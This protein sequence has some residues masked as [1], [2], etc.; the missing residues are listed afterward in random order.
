MTASMFLAG[1]IL[2]GLLAAQ[3]Y[4]VYEADREYKEALDE[5]LRNKKK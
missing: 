4:K 3:L 2:F 1:V 5:H